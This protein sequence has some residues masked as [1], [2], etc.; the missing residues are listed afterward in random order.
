MGVV[1][2][3]I[4]FDQGV[5]KVCQLD[6]TATAIVDFVIQDV[7]MMIVVDSNPIAMTVG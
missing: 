7:Y 4:V 2:Y 1:V 5:I 3:N 6:A